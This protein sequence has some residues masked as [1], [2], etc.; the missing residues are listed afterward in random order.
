M[1]SDFAKK[2]Y[3]TYL[4]VFEILERIRD[5]RGLRVNLDSIRTSL[6]ADLSQFSTT[7]PDEQ[8]AHRALVYWIDEVLTDSKVGEEWRLKILEHELFGTRDRAQFFF[9]DAEEAGA[10]GRT[11]AAETF[12]MCAALGFRGILRGG[13]PAPRAVVPPP[14]APPPIGAE[15]T[16]QVP[17]GEATQVRPAP[18][19]PRTPEVPKG[20]EATPQLPFDFNAK[21]ISEGSGGRR[22]AA[23]PILQMARQVLVNQPVA[24]VQPARVASAGAAL[25]YGAIEDWSKKVLARILAGAKGRYQPSLAPESAGE[26][27]PLRGR[28]FLRRATIAMLVLMG[29]ALA[30]F[31]VG[32]LAG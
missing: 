13:Q 5:P 10:L 29:S 16:Q 24:P 3:T 27:R 11:D 20:P 2:V 19:P 18:A 12:F 26:C 14:D 31:G 9:S 30:L 6:K 1:T 23:G 4:H 15:K 32:A 8:L 25:P 22:P 28:R 21:T 7:S 17:L